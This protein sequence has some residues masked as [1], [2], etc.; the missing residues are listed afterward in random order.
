MRWLIPATKR[1]HAHGAGSLKRVAL[2]REKE[3]ALIGRHHQRGGRASLTYLAI[4]AIARSPMGTIRSFLPCPGAPSA[5]PR[6]ASEVVA[7][8]GRAILSEGTRSSAPAGGPCARGHRRR[9]PLARPQI[10]PAGS[11][12][13]PRD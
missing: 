7:R 10:L 13:T 1:F 4:H 12:P 3:H 5:S 6:S 2:L 8:Q 11:S 9:P